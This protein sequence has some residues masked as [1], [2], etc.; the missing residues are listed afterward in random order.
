MLLLTC[1]RFSRSGCLT[2]AA[3]ALRSA[4]SSAILRVNA[5]ASTARF[6][7]RWKRDVAISSIVRVILR[8]LRIA[9][10]RLTIARVLAMLFGLHQNARVQADFILLEE[11]EAGLAAQTDRLA[12]LQVGERVGGNRHLDAH[13]AVS[14]Q[15]GVTE[16]VLRLALVLH[17][18]GDDQLLVLVLGGGGLGVLDELRGQVGGGDGHQV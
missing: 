14:L 3:L 6:S 13:L 1:S 2:F 18:A 16:A 10:R 8:M 15:A 7:A 11:R 5:S 12:R 17:F 9:L 4:A